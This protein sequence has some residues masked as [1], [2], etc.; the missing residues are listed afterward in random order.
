MSTD[1]NYPLDTEHWNTEEI[2]DVVNFYHLVEK[3]NESGVKREDLM[4]AYSR[5]KQIVPSKSEEKTLG[6][7]FEKQS[8]YSLYK[9]IKQA[10]NTSEGEVV[11][12]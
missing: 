10:R 1:Y 8:G 7:E 2:I 12:L 9:T 5:F 6:S 11:K 4:H 3:A